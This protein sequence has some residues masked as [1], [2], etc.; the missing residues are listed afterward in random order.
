MHAERFVC[1]VHNRRATSETARNVAAATKRLRVRAELLF[2]LVL[3]KWH[4]DRHG[5]LCVFVARRSSR[6]PLPH[7]LLHTLTYKEEI[8][9]DSMPGRR[10]TRSYQVLNNNWL[11]VVWTFFHWPR[12]RIITKMTFTNWPIIWS[13]FFPLLLIKGKKVRALPVLRTS[14]TRF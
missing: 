8:D 5:H 2:I 7:R 6:P 10:L 9:Q 13:D 1:R 14:G 12:S 4:Q 11:N 3:F